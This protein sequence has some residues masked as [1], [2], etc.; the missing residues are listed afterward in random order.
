MVQ[1]THL[2][3]DLI[4][5]GFKSEFYHKV[6]GDED[7]GLVP[8]VLQELR[9]DVSLKPPLP[10]DDQAGRPMKGLPTKKH[11]RSNGEESASW[12]YNAQRPVA[13]RPPPQGEE[14]PA[15]L[16]GHSSL[17]GHFDLTGDSNP[18]HYQRPTVRGPPNLVSM[19]DVICRP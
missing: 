17:E 19:V 5:A 7:F 14:W 1:T 4:D 18:L 16:D 13:P 12:R 6:H 15:S 10:V 8:P 9:R 2:A 11:I 3:M